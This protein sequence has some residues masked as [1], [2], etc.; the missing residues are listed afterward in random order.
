MTASNATMAQRGSVQRLSWSGLNK[1]LRM[2]IILGVLLVL[3][4]FTT[5]P[6]VY[7]IT[8]A[9][10]TNA[11][12][13]S[14]P[15]TLIPRNPTNDN[16]LRL[17][18]GSEIPFVRQFTNSVFIATTQT[19]LSL[20]VSSWVGW[21]FAKYSFRGKNALFMF[22]LAT[23]MFP[24][25]VSLVPLFLLM[26]K[27]GWLDTYWAIIIPG[28]A[29]AFGVFFMRQIMLGVPD[30]LLDAGRIDG[31]SEFG[32]YWRIGLPLAGAG[33][34]ILSVLSF[35]GAWNNYMWPL[36]VL[37]TADKFTFPVGLASLYGLYKIE[38]GMILGGSTLATL[39]I[40]ILF[41]LGR[42]QFV[43]GITQGAIKG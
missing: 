21:G 1:R 37:R 42:D 4:L 8:G 15:L 18:N 19:L 16:Y 34:S 31:S 11:E 6:F 7:M 28:A 3:S 12:I 32:M 9:F 20:L 22:L 36:I 41:I 14:Y 43:A 5:M 2:A 38:Y 39:P 33:L 10:K 35:L 13:F 25:Q 23:M 30:E 27:F 40:L 29:S 24:G 17:L 26:L